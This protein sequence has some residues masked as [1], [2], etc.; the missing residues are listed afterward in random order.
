[1]A[2]TDV[3]VL[4]DESSD[5]GLEESQ[6]KALD[7]LAQLGAQP[8]SS[9]DAPWDS[10]PQIRMYQMM[11][12]G[13]VGGKAAKS[14]KSKRNQH[15]RA[16]ANVAEHVRT[17][18]QKKM[19]DALSRALDEEAGPRVNLDAIKL[20][21]EIEHKED[22]LVLKEEAHDNELDNAPKDELLAELI[23]L[24]TEPAT[25]SIIEASFEEI[26]DATVVGEAESPPD[27]RSTGTNR[28]TPTAKTIRRHPRNA[29]HNGSQG[30]GVHRKTGKGALKKIARQRATDG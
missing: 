16:A 4:D 3:A 2:T 17:K 22:E 20:A 25:S 10:N 23:K 27:S 29:G 14:S 18:L 7:R 28:A 11:Y 12:E 8:R 30:S 21:L 5:S 6:V 15:T 1:M 26:K 13:L 19:T 9:P 24:V